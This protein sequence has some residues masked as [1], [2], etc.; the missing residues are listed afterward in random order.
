MKNLFWVVFSVLLAVTV[1]LSYLLFVPSQKFS[2]QIDA[3]LKNQGTNKFAILD[4][5]EP[6]GRSGDRLPEVSAAI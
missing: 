3:T 4:A 6:N 1:H 2:A 5:P